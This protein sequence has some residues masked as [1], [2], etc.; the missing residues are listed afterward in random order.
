MEPFRGVQ[1]RGTETATQGQKSGQLK[2]E[3]KDTLQ[4]AAG[5]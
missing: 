4:L 1:N 5:P 2:E 3:D